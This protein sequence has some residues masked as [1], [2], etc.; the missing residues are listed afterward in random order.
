V[1]W[2]QRAEPATKSALLS[3]MAALFASLSAAA[4]GAAEFSARTLLGG[5]LIVLAAVLAAKK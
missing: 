4:L 2:Q 5:S 1:W 3:D